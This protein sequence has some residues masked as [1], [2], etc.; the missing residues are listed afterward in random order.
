MDTIRDIIRATMRASVQNRVKRY[1]E[2]RGAGLSCMD[3][4]VQTK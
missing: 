4:H 3:T 1:P 2:P